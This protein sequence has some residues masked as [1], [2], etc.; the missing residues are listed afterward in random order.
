M[1]LAR[2]KSCLSRVS[3][4]VRAINRFFSQANDQIATKLSH[5]GSQ[6][7]QHP[8]C[9]QGQGQGQL[10]AGYC[11]FGWLVSR[12]A[13]HHFVRVD[14]VPSRK[15]SQRVRAYEL[16]MIVSNNAVKQSV[17]LIKIVFRFVG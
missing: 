1:S 2:G 4:S 6:V 3:L 12:V 10:S 11:H 13:R 14:S 8:G 15:L 16:V 5:D 17:V 9:A 7:S